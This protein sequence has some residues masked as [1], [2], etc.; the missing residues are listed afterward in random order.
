M[1]HAVR[2][3]NIKPTSLDEDHLQK[4]LQNLY[5]HLTPPFST[6]VVISHDAH[7]RKGNVITC[8]INIAYGKQM[9]RAERTGSSIASAIDEA[10]QALEHELH[11]VH[12]KKIDQSRTRKRLGQ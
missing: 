3:E 9:L 7:H 4:K 8:R 2:Y 12:D 11:K 5:R 1:K 10:T 6:D